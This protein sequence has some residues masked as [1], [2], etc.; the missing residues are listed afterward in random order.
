MTEITW[1]ISQMDCIPDVDG[2]QDY[3][4]TTHW[5]CKKPCEVVALKDAG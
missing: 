5:Q 2:K 1:T 3:V 4:V